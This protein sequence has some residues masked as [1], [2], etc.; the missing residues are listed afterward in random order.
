MAKKQNK[1]SPPKDQDFRKE[2]NR[3]EEQLKRAL[4]D[5]DNLEKRINREKNRWI[6]SANEALIDKLLF[7]FDDLER[8]CQ[9]LKDPGLS[10][11]RDQFW[12]ILS[13]E[14]VEKIS[15]QGELFDPQLMDAQ[16]LVPGPK[17]KVIE[18]TCPGYLYQGKCLRPA[19]VKV[20][21]GKK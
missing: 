7:V 20:G 13:G 15:G 17:E 21:Q 12:Q 14:G 11:V 8:A 4:A 2:L 5:Y 9:N 16:E 18:E 6:N 19:K 1:K 3:L 10:M